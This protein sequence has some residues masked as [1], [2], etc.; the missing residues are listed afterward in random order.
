MPRLD[1]SE[2]IGVVKIDNKRGPKTDPCETPV[3]VFVLL[4]PMDTKLKQSDKYNIQSTFRSLTTFVIAV[5][6]EWNNKNAKKKQLKLKLPQGCC[7]LVGRWKLRGNQLISI[8]ITCL[9]FNY[10]VIVCLMLWPVSELL[11]ESSCVWSMVFSVLTEV[12]SPWF[13][14]IWIVIDVL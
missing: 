3:L 11:R 5:S 6:V 4:A 7:C 12:D 14:Y 9:L 8:V 13:I 10:D 1:I 2:P